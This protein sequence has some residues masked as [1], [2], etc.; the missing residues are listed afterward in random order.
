MGMVLL[1]STVNFARP[2]GVSFFYSLTRGRGRVHRNIFRHLGIVKFFSC[3]FFFFFFFFFQDAQ[4]CNLACYHY[5]VV[6]G[7]SQ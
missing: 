4:L 3:F 5:S 2:N 7:D 6:G 1:T